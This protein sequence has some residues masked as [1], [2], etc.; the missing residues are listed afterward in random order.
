MSA[1]MYSIIRGQRAG[2]FQCSCAI[3]D[4][5]ITAS[6]ASIGLPLTI[7][8]RIGILT[9]SIGAFDSDCCIA[10]SVD[11]EIACTYILQSNV[12]LSPFSR[13]YIYIPFSFEEPVITGAESGLL[14]TITV[15]FSESF[16]H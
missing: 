15:G 9:D 3:I 13:T 5:Y 1:D 12:R 4:A 10:L 6:R 7:S 11:I 16:V 2:A 14:S 8:P